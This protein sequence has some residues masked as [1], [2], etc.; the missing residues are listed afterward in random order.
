MGA[1]PH[2]AS[3]GSR[4]VSTQ[5]ERSLLLAC[6]SFPN[7]VRLMRGVMLGAPQGG[8]GITAGAHTSLN[9]SSPA[10]SLSPLSS[11]PGQGCLPGLL[12][13]EYVRR[14]GFGPEIR[15]V[16][17]WVG[18]EPRVLA[19]DGSAQSTWLGV[20]QRA[21]GFTGLRLLLSSPGRRENV[22]ECE[23]CENDRAGPK[24]CKLLVNV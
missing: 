16:M 2:P 21:A 13:G 6:L 11:Q 7:S 8:P 23:K 22:K 4:A 10:V 3:L 9:F 18:Y 15:A 5:L 1:R 12:A 19:E 20:L 17:P 14:R 24:I